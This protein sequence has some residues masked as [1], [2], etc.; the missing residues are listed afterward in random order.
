MGNG[1]TRQVISAHTGSYNVANPTKCCS[2]CEHG[3][4]EGTTYTFHSDSA[5]TN[6]AS[7]SSFELKFTDNPSFGYYCRF[8][9]T[10][11]PQPYSGS[12]W[13]ATATSS[14]YAKASALHV[15]TVYRSWSD[16]QSHCSLYGGRL[17]SIYS[18]AQNSA[19]RA[20][21]DAAGWTDHVWL[22]GSDEASEGVWTWTEGVVFSNGSTAVN[23]AYVNWYVTA[24]HRA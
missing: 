18:A 4:Y 23:G 9:S 6:V 20:A 8:Y 1:W 15:D 11:Q 5:G 21:V 16:A 3:T 10:S 24:H 2:I 19:V 12:E 22:G 7:C 13:I 17:V 14:F